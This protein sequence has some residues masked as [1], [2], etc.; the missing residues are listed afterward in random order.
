MSALGGSKQTFES[1][2]PDGPSRLLM[3][4]ADQAMSSGLAASS[5]LSHR[6]AHR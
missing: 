1:V 5:T 4:A 6:N 2:V 3:R